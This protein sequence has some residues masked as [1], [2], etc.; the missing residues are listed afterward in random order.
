MVNLSGVHALNDRWSVLGDIMFMQ[1]SDIQSV[2]IR[3]VTTGAS[4]GT[5]LQ[6]QFKDTV[7]LSAAVNYRPAEKWL[8]RA[9]VAWDQSPVRGSIQRT[10]SLPDSD[11]MWLTFGARWDISKAHRLDFAYGHVFIQESQINRTSNSMTLQGDY[12]NSANIVSAQYTLSF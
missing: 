11:R 3:R 5:V 6:Y 7:R 8:W 2:D 10:A 9:G 12:S 4:T 1:W